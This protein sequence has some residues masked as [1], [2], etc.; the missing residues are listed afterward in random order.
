M[1]SP[2]CHLPRSHR[3]V[4][5]AKVNAA[6]AHLKDDR[7]FTGRLFL[8]HWFMHASMCVSAGN[9]IDAIH[10]GSNL[11]IANFVFLWLLVITQVRHANNQVATLSVFQYLHYVARG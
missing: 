11:R 3:E 10:L 6:L 9:E 1:T 8:Y 5:S 2:R 7:L 4:H